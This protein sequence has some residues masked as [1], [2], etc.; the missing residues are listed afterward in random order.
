MSPGVTFG[1]TFFPRRVASTV[2]HY[3]PF[4]ATQRQ[5]AIPR[6]TPSEMTLRD[7]MLIGEFLRRHHPRLA[8]D[9]AL[10]GFPGPD[11]TTSLLLGDLAPEMADLAWYLPREAT[12]RHF[13]TASH[14]SL[15]TTPRDFQGVHLVFLMVLL[16]IAGLSADPAPACPKRTLD[17]QAPLEPRV[18][19]RMETT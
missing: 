2:G 5:S 6:L 13:A 19:R 11:G 17:N 9:I 18:A 8:H 7:R 4:L 1:T 16:R 14:T 15:V 12:E 10:H 3:A